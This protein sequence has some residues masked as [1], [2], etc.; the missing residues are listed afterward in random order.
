MAAAA[1]LNYF[2]GPQ[3]SD[4]VA[5][6]TENPAG[7]AA[8][9]NPSAVS[10]PN[11]E[12]PAG[13]VADPDAGREAALTVPKQSFFE[14]LFQ[15]REAARAA[16]NVA[17]FNSLISAR[18]LEAQAKSRAGKSDQE[19]GETLKS[20]YERMK[21]PDVTTLAAIDF[22]TDAK[23]ILLIYEGLVIFPDGSD[24]IVTRLVQFILENN[25]WK[26]DEDVIDYRGN[27]PREITH[28]PEITIE[29]IE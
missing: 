12:T 20:G 25:Q 28:P 19:F 2:T 23:T 18:G 29:P 3:A 1:G 11:Q 17:V 22:Q 24:R 26:V 15:K 9:D 10:G 16:G 21:N 27:Q 4:P 8:F 14:D 6:Q 7:D 5:D 13:F